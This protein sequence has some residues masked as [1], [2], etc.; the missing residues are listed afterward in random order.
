ME[1]VMELIYIWINNTSNNILKN[2]DVML[3][4][5]YYIH[6]D[7]EIN[8][9]KIQKNDNYYNIFKNS[10]ISNVNVIVGSNGAGKTTLLKYIYNND[11][12]PYEVCN[13]HRDI[14]RREED[15]TIQVYKDKGELLIVHNLKEDLTIASPIIY[16]VNK[17][18]CGENESS[19]QDIVPRTKIY[20]TNSFY[21]DIQGIGFNND[22]PDNIAL[23]N[24]NLIT[25]KS[26]FYNQC[27]NFPQ[28]G[29]RDNNYNG[30]QEII[31]NKRTESN[32]QE[33]CDL[34]YFN[35]LKKEKKLDSFIGRIS[36]KIN[37]QSESLINILE[38]ANAKK[39]WVRRYHSDIDYS[40]RI[41]E[42]LDL[43]KEKL[44][45]FRFDS[46]NVI[47]TLEKNLIL[48]LDFIYDLFKNDKEVFEEDDILKIC[49]NMLKKI[50]DE[51]EKEYYKN[52]IK[53]IKDLRKILYTENGILDCNE[54]KDKYL[55]FLG[56]IEKVINNQ[57]SFVLKYL[58]INEM[59]MS[60]GERAYLNIL[61][62]I[63]LIPFFKQIVPGKIKEISNKYM[64][65]LIDE[66]DL[67]CHPEWQRKMVK[68]ILDEL[69]NQFEGKEIQVIFTTHSPIILS[70]IPLSNT[71]Y[72]RR[73]DDFQSVIDDRVIHKE[74]FA[75]NI[76]QL[77]N[78]SFFLQGKSAIGEYAL[79][80]ING[81][82]S[83]IKTK[84][85]EKEKEI[86]FKLNIIGEP[87][88]RNKLTKM[89]K[90]NLENAY[91]KTSTNVSYTRTER[92]EE[93]DKVNLMN[94]KN[95]LTELLNQ[96]N[97]ML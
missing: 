84:Q 96:V 48:E 35:K 67:Y 44:R 91:K 73:E 17:T 40:K 72:I 50:Q 77:F 37:L 1:E 45:E 54:T 14:K 85:V 38:N 13:N 25:F 30:L 78:D 68:N 7:K 61:S 12:L 92:T 29:I 56:F 76:Y 28:G 42:K 4:D 6:F 65:I 31:I 52:A 43:W 47:D 11:I 5:E 97:K 79:N 19:L 88:I 83:D 20:L 21:N 75:A 33:I 36:T 16:R 71:T 60:S 53:E 70:D 39:Q 15:L 93:F 32:F 69:E 26:N 90:E 86:K 24:Q 27:I 8:K 66:I 2:Q 80:L 74:T 23:T 55:K 62:W 46:C 64:I 95:Q 22:I 9:L 18:V 94:I 57:Q 34:L 59:T 81:V 10:V 49:S 87:I 63:N 89:L 82:I 58:N 41:E 3:T 51:K